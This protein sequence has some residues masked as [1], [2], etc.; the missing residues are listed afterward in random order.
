MREAYGKC[1]GRRGSRD[2]ENGKKIKMG[3]VGVCWKWSW[4]VGAGGGRI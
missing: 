3:S 2:E 1:G 4:S